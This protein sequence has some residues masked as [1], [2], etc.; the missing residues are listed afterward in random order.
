[1][2]H[3]IIYLQFTYKK[4][5]SFSTK[6]AFFAFYRLCFCVFVNECAFDAVRM[7]NTHMDNKN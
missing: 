7:S 5:I 3:V 6:F 1:M 2:D 4:V